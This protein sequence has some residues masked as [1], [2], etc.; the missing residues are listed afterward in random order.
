[1]ACSDCYP[2]NT[3]VIT[4]G[5]GIQVYGSGVPGD[6]FVISR[7]DAPEGDWQQSVWVDTTPGLDVSQ[8]A[9]PTTIETRL[10]AFAALT[11][12]TWSPAFAGSLTFIIQQGGAGSYEVGWA[13]AGVLSASTINLSNAVGAKDLVRVLWTGAYWIAT[14]IVLNVT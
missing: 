3:T 9:R 10:T 13:A 5:D 8:F 12:P 1:M 6:P 2:G 11:L 14:D 7:Y 4:S